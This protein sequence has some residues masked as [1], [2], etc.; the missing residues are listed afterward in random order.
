MNIYTN[1]NCPEACPERVDMGMRLSR[2][3]DEVQMKTSGNGWLK[4][5]MQE[6]DALDDSR[7]QETR[8]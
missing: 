6:I 1:K 2:Y 8:K 3:G 7:C 5:T 4:C